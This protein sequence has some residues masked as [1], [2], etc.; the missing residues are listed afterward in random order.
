MKRSLSFFIKYGV[1]SAWIL[2]GISMTSCSKDSKAEGVTIPF[3]HKTHVENYAI[4]DCGTCHKYDVNGVFQ[5]RPTVGECTAC[6]NRGNDYYTDDRKST[7]RKK[8]MFDSFTNK[9]RLWASHVENSD[10]FYYSHKAKMATT[11]ADTTTRVRCDLC[12]G[13]K[14]SSAGKANIKGEKLMEQCIYCHSA[15]KMN[16]QCDVCHR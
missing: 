16:N 8:T 3:S 1:I 7:P 14:A 9:D 12:H 13:D 4:K 11:I 15:L 2:L 5:G 6:H 10:L